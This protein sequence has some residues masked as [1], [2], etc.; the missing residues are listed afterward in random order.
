VSDGTAPEFRILALDGGGIKGVFA[1]SFLAG[2]EES[3]G[4]PLVDHFDLIVGTSTGGI[5]ALGL[6]MGLSAQ[7]LLG[8]YEQNGP[9]ILAGGRRKI[10]QQIFSAKYDSAPLCTALED[11]FRDRLLGESKTRL[12]IPSLNLESGEVHVFKTAHHDR[13]IRDY[14]ERVVDVALATS[15]AP[16]YFPTHHLTSGTPL[17]DGGMWANNPM[18]TAAVE[19]LGV[20]EWP[21][22]AIKLLGV[23][24]TESPLD[25]YDRSRRG[26]GVNYW[27]RRLVSIFMAG[28][29]SSSLGTAQ[30][31]LGHENVH[32]VSPSV[33]G[34]R[35]RLDRVDGIRSLKGLG[36]AE[37]RKE[38]PRV[39]SMFLT[40]NRQP[41]TPFHEVGR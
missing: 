35:Y 36:S 14:K 4:A 27:A 1:A 25:T 12:V 2:I 21:R 11:V 20:L 34:E 22:G 17:I 16:T 28:Q 38:Y 29:S 24:C 23:G 31:L 13:F 9:A 7:E 3:L 41:F 26:L 32:R 5:I 39:R 37:A 18:G 19:A 8:F 6:G 40:A 15:A 30:L 33:D 10:I